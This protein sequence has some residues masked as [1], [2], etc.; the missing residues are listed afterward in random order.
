VSV[1][2]LLVGFW[3]ARR[4][5]ARRQG[6][7]F[8]L[9]LMI[10]PLVGLLVMVYGVQAKLSGRHSWP[11]WIGAALAFGVGLAA[12]DGVRWWRWPVWGAALLIVALPARVDTRPIYDSRLREAFAY[13]RA[14]S[15]PGDVLIL[16]DGTLFT[17]AG[18]Y[19]TN[20]PWIGLPPDKLTDVKRFL[21]FDEALDSLNTLA[22]GRIVRRAWV[23]AWQGD[24]MDPQ[25]LVA[26]IFEALGDPVP[27]PLGFGDVSVSLY[28]LRQPPDALR[29]RVARLGPPVQVPPDGSIY[30]G[31]YILNQG[32]M[33]R[34]GTVK[35]QTWWRR[36]DVVMSGLRVSVRL[37]DADGNYYTQT[38]QPPVSAS[39]GQENWRPGSPIL[40]RFTV[41]VPLEMPPGPA[42]ARLI[43][44]DIG[45][46][47]EPVSV[48]IGRLDIVD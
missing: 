24:I 23:V 44:Y 39:F 3:M 46:T 15:R 18:Y 16:R 10:V 30:V 5:P 17:A 8:A 41:L 48:I 28:R 26:G 1:I 2:A 20:L 14:N 47:F 43:L 31:G 36:G 42:E 19:G 35:I 6:V 27:I 45:G 4:V 40:S 21:F 32:P 7:I 25:N 9:A 12:L 22:Q 13:I 29:E 11:I 34:G 33:P 37:Y 38:D